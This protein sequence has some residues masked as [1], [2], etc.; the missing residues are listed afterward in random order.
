VRHSFDRTP[1]VPWHRLTTPAVLR[2]CPL[3]PRPAG[4]GSVR[5]E[6]MLRYGS[7]SYALHGGPTSP[8]V[9]DL[10][11]T[12]KPEFDQAGAARRSVITRHD[13]CTVRP[14]GTRPTRGLLG[15]PTAG[16]PRS[17]TPGSAV[18]RRPGPAARTESVAHS[19]RLRVAGLPDLQRVVMAAY[20]RDRSAPASTGGS[21]MGRAW[22]GPC[23][24]R[25][26]CGDATCRPAGGGGGRD[27]RARARGA[28]PSTATA[29]SAEAE[30][31]PAAP[32]LRRGHVRR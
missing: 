23:P 28:P 12:L 22:S 5:G 18:S 19:N 1:E 26:S 25:H 14:R 30:P 31:T 3:A 29:W 17:T 10:H 32:R 21:P 13:V 8:G 27:A 20:D 24:C 4:S 15:W 7:G 16:S 2:Q 9:Q 11:R 6:P